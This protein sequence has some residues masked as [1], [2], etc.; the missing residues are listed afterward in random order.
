MRSYYPEI[1]F[2]HGEDAAALRTILYLCDPSTKR[3]EYPEVSFAVIGALTRGLMGIEA[4]AR[5]GSVATRPRLT[6]ELAEAEIKNVPVLDAAISVKHTGRARTEFQNAGPAAVVWRAGFPGGWDTIAVDGKAQK[7]ELA[8]DE[9]GAVF[10]FVRLK[11]EAGRTAS[12][13]AVL[14]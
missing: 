1:F 8:K 3:R 12:A 4:D 13:A 6:G 14:R 9:A 10:S 7:A 5:D 2:R 11:V